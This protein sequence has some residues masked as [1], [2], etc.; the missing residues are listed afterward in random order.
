MWH[1]CMSSGEKLHTRTD[2]AYSNPP[3][4]QTQPR[5]VTLQQEISSSG[6]MADGSGT[7]AQPCRIPSKTK[8]VAVELEK[9]SVSILSLIPLTLCGLRGAS[10]TQLPGINISCCT[11]PLI[12]T[13]DISPEVDSISAFLFNKWDC[14]SLAV[15][16]LGS[17]HE[18]PMQ[19]RS[20]QISH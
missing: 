7:K 11:Q 17:S 16:P 10:R 5:R 14:A 8:P 9:F 19:I 1:V 3:L 20:H 12:S 6:N 13:S 15:F 2:L 4:K 18:Q